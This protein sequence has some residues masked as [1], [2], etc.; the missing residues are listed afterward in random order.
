I[1]DAEL[2][3]IYFP[4]FKAALETGA[5]NVM[6]GYMD[7]N[8]VPATGNRWLFTDVLRGKLGFTGFVVS[9]ANAVRNLL[10]HGFAADLTDAGA[11]A[12]IAGVDREMAMADPAYARLPEA[13]Q[14]GAVSEETLDASV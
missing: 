3:N 13:L 10:T 7:L 12:L 8:G 2:W 6:T 14:D 9:D 1:S 5:G 11:R 4:P